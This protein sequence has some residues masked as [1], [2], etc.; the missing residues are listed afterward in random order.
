V[1]IHYLIRIQGSGQLHQRERIHGLCFL[2]L[3][4]SIFSRGETTNPH[5]THARISHLHSRRPTHKRLH[6]MTYKL[7]PS[8]IEKI[9][10]PIKLILPSVSIP[11][12]PDIPPSVLTDDGENL[13]KL[14]KAG[15]EQQTILHFDSA[16]DLAEACFDRPYVVK[17]IEAVG[18]R[19]LLRACL[20]ELQPVSFD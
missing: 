3:S 17:S 12:L 6:F 9:N 11:T 1:A 16:K 15:E 14:E 4:H 8:I 13:E 5:Q 18:N 20:A 2:G 7:D 10:G 19:V